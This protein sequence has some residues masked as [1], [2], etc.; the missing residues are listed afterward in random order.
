MCVCV[1]VQVYCIHDQQGIH[2]HVEQYISLHDC[3]SYMLEPCK[4]HNH[5]C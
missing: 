2:V 1:E 5:V 3:G 4:N